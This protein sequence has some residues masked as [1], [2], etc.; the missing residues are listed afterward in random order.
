MTLSQ[1]YKKYISENPDSKLTFGEWQDSVLTPFIK[2]AIDQIG[3]INPAE[4]AQK[5]EGKIIGADQNFI[6]TVEFV[7]G[8]GNLVVAR[9]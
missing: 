1:Q 4:W 6:P 3:E 8:A 9:L 7:L 5:K 2:G